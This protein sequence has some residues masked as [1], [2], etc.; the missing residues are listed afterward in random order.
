[1]CPPPAAAPA[2]IL[3]VE[4]DRV[5]RRFLGACLRH[6]GHDVRAA[7]DGGEALRALEGDG[8]FDLVLLGV[9]AGPALSDALAGRRPGTRV[10]MLTN[11]D[12]ERSFAL[13]KPNTVE[14]VIET[15]ALAL[16]GRPAGRGE[17]RP[18]GADVTTREGA[19]LSGAA[20]V[21]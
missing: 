4:D 14:S 15:L 5:Y 13:P 17:A 16:A 3:L 20:G 9:D 10:L 18:R 6:L 2:R 11:R 1:M 19:A 7:D 12:D 8:A 21:P